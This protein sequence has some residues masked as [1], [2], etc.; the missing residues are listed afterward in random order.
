MRDDER[1]A[2]LRAISD[3]YYVYIVVLQVYIGR[4]VNNN[5][6]RI[7]E[8]TSATMAIVSTRQYDI[9]PIVMGRII[10]EQ[11][12]YQVL[13]APHSMSESAESARVC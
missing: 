7:S 3:D 11:D 12:E 1:D 9:R 5:G 13:N 2:G 10:I 6:Y 4:H 8:S